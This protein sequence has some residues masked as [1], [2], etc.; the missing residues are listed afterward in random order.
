M[1]I[2][3]KELMHSLAD[4]D[5]SDLDELSDPA[6]EAMKLLLGMAMG[7]VINVIEAREWEHRKR[8]LADSVELVSH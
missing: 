7:K 3:I 4:V 5:E 6:L 1:S 8:F 2:K